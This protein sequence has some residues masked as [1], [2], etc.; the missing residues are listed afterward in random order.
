MKKVII[1]GA[2]EGI[3]R[4]LACI[5][6]KQHCVVGIAA[7]RAELLARLKDE[8]GE[9]VY[10]MRMDVSQTDEAAARFNA[11]VEAMGGADIV[12]LCAGTGYLNP[13]LRW[14]DEEATIDVN[15]KGFTCLAD[16]AFH[17]FAA[18]G[19]GQLA[20]I[21]SIAALRGSAQCPAYNASKAYVSNYM[22]G[23]RFKAAKIGRNITITDVRP[24]FVD[25]KMAQ[26]EGLFWVASPQKAA[27]QIAALIAKRK[28]LGYVTKRWRIVAYLLRILP[29]WLYA[30]MQ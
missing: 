25:T 30:K 20:A 1:I 11:L 17:C 18:R 24:G 27:A 29:D 7:R 8:L 23:L 10:T 15:V 26:G 12:I 13:Q 4:E 16:A 3:G 22:E 19:H 28:K 9:N 5:Y 14:D 21:S 2:S 6:A